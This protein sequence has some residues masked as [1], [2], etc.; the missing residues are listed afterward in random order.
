M[1]AVCLGSPRAADFDLKMFSNNFDRV[2]EYAENIR[3]YTMYVQV[4]EGA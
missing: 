4:E 1:A 2:L 3:V